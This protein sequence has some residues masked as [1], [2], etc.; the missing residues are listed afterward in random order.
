MDFAGE[1]SFSFA[2]YF[3]VS[4]GVY[5]FNPL[6]DF[7][8]RFVWFCLRRNR[9]RRRGS[10]IDKSDYYTKQVPIKKIPSTE[11]HS[12]CNQVFIPS[13]G[14]CL[15][16]LYSIKYLLKQNVAKLFNA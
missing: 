12:K 6:S 8:F 3:F 15:L 16:F 7:I 4:L 13:L 2:Y 10:D 5:I 9:L 14:I 11:Q 1:F